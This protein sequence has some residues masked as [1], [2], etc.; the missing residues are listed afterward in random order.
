MS[1]LLDIAFYGFL[2][3]VAC[4]ALWVLRA[5]HIDAYERGYSQGFEDASAGQ[6]PDLIR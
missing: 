5:L 2:L 3:S 4:S 1:L 6:Y